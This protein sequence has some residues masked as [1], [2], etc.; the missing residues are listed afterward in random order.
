MADNFKVCSGCNQSLSLEDNFY[1]IK[2]NIS[3]SVRYERYCKDCKRQ[4]RKK[5]FSK[6]PKTPELPEAHVAVSIANDIT[7]QDSTAKI[8]K[9]YTYPNGKTLTLTKEEFE[10]F[11]DIFEILLVEDQKRNSQVKNQEKGT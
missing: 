6:T 10:G 4:R 8:F 7:T 9:T 5:I 2:D 11:V 1:A 3:K